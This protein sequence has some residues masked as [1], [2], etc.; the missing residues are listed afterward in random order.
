[1]R[2][3]ISKEQEEK[4]QK[5]NQLAIGSILILVMVLSVLGYS[6]GSEKESSE[7]IVYNGFEFTKENGFW[8]LNIENAKFSFQYNPREVESINPV[9]NPIENYLN[10]PLYVYSADAE[11]EAEFYRNLFYDNSIVERVQKACPENEVCEAGLPV[12]TCSDNFII[13]KE[14]DNSEI[15][16]TENCLFIEGKREDLVKISDSALFKIIG[17]Q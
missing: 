2:K 14:S 10:K 12:K 4:K 11:A 17:I 8:I 13:I 7:K 6:L 1:M 9:L 16:Q 5:R 3:I 15:K